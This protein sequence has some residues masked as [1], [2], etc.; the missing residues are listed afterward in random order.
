M[1]AACPT[2]NELL[3]AMKLCA[4]SPISARSPPQPPAW[5]IKV[6]VRNGEPAALG[7]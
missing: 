3:P 1:Y 2:P 6:L 4:P 7:R 5:A